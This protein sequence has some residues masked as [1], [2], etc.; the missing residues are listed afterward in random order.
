[1][2]VASA[3]T[4]RCLWCTKCEGTPEREGSGIAGAGTVRTRASSGS[5]LRVAGMP[6]GQDCCQL[7]QSVCEEAGE[8]DSAISTIKSEL[9]RL[10]KL[11]N[12]KEVQIGI[13]I[14]KLTQQVS[15]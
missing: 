9:S 13:L 8:L 10:C 6:A 3:H 4:C 5:V 11:R 2:S 1:M 14:D 7:L 15:L 12:K